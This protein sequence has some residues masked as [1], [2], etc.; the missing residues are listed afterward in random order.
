MF[1]VT[2]HVLDNYIHIAFILRWLIHSSVLLPMSLSNLQ[3]CYARIISL[4]CGLTFSPSIWNSPVLF[5]HFSHSTAVDVWM[6]WRPP[7]PNHFFIMGT[8]F[9]STISYLLSLTCSYLYFKDFKILILIF[10][11]S[12]ECGLL[13]M[14]PLCLGYTLPALPLHV[15]SSAGSAT[16]AIALTATLL[17]SMTACMTP[18]ISK[19]LFP[20]CLVCIIKTWF[21]VLIPCN[22]SWIN[23][24]NINGSLVCIFIT[25]YA[26][27]DD[28]VHWSP[29]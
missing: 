18:C 29:A 8:F 11:W 25:W 23:K 28:Y 12:V 1:V 24:D 16:P 3:Y 17:I 21:L 14:W 5:L 2:Y 22:V 4:W 20:F 7:L 19:I 15:L 6:K 26:L 27:T 9:A 10:C 13:K